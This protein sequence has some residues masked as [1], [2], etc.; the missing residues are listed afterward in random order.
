MQ[1]KYNRKQTLKV[2]GINLL[3]RKK[4]DKHAV[5]WHSNIAEYIEIVQKFMALE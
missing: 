5:A 3:R 1:R 2:F 4:N